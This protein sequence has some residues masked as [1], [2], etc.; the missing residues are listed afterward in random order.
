MVAVHRNHHLVFEQARLRI[1]PRE[2]DGVADVD[3]AHAAAWVSLAGGAN[4]LREAIREGLVLLVATRA[5]LSAVA[6]QPSVTLDA[7]IGLSAGT[8]GG[9]SH[10]GNCQS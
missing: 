1:A 10:D 9:R 5:R 4:T 7:D 8:C 6:G 3:E 2:R